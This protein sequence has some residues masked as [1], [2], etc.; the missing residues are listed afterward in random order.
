MRRNSKPRVLEPFS[1]VAKSLP[2]LPAPFPSIGGVLRSGYESMLLVRI[3]GIDVCRQ[4][5]FQSFLDC[6]TAKMLDVRYLMSDTGDNQILYMQLGFMA[7]EGLIQSF[8]VGD[9]F[10]IRLTELGVR[11]AKD[12]DQMVLEYLSEQLTGGISAS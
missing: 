4:A 9:T 7:A 12:Y 5:I 2:E 11:K 3:E 1:S 8:C 10:F 6:G